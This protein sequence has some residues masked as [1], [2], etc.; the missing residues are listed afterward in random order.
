MIV[1]PSH[2]EL[3]RATPARV[4]GLLTDYPAMKELFPVVH[5][6]EVVRR[7][8]NEVEI[9]VKRS[10]TIGRTVH[11][12]DYYAPAPLMQFERHYLQVEGGMKAKSLWTVEPAWNGCAYFTILSEAKLPFFPGIVMRPLLMRMFYGINFPPVIR[13][14]EHI[15]KTPLK[16]QWLLLET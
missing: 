13:A 7:E 15:D 6:I 12:I 9:I 16:D 5:Q 8:R 11:F 14:A 4:F 10:T 2:T 1:N 3:I